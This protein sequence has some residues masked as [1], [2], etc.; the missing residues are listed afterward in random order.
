[1]I[2]NKRGVVNPSQYYAHGLSLFR[3]VGHRNPCNDV[4]FQSPIQY[5]M[6]QYLQIFLNSLCMLNVLS[7]DI[8]KKCNQK[9]GSLFTFAI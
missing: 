7:I 9:P 5:P 6:G 2:K 8:F 3:P 4:G 1:M